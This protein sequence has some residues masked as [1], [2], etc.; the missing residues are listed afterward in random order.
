VVQDIEKITEG[1]SNNTF[2]G[3]NT[4]APSAPDKTVEDIPRNI[5]N[6]EN[7]WFLQ[8]KKLN[9]DRVLSFLKLKGDLK[10]GNKTYR[11][12]ESYKK[13]HELTLN[14]KL[15]VAQYWEALKNEDENLPSSA[16]KECTTVLTSALNEE[17]L[18][19]NRNATVFIFIVIIIS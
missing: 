5:V 15:K 2:N 1:S 18:Q 4:T 3:T 7:E 11:I 12:A 10:V 19:E 14:Q 17:I 6:M 13:Y 16:M 8:G 9:P